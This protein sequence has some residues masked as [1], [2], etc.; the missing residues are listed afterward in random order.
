[1]TLKSLPPTQDMESFTKR[2]SF[3]QIV[4][5]FA[6]FL[7]KTYI[8]DLRYGLVYDEICDNFENIRGSILSAKQDA[9]LNELNAKLRVHITTVTFLLI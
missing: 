2:Y 8:I 6:K 3:L 5:C 7:I 9:T 4:F 1:M